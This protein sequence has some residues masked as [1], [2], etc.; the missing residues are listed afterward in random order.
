MLAMKRSL[1]SYAKAGEQIGHLATSC[2]SY[3]LKEIKLAL[4]LSNTSGW[5]EYSLVKISVQGRGRG[6]NGNK[7]SSYF[8]NAFV[9]LPLL[10]D[11]H[12][13]IGNVTVKE[14]T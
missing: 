2:H 11:Q 12:L 3:I 10:N 1:S 8:A 4:I 9:S 14:K 7:A 6:R 5:I 13:C